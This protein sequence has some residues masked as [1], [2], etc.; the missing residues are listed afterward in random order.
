MPTPRHRRHCHRRR[1]RRRCRQ[2]LRPGRRLRH[3]RG[4][5]RRRWRRPPEGRAGRSACGSSPRRP[6]RRAAPGGGPAAC[7]HRCRT[8][9][10]GTARSP[11][12][13]AAVAGRAVPARPKAPPTSAASWAAPGKRTQLGVGA[14]VGAG[15]GVGVEVRVGVRVGV[16]VLG[17]RGPEA[18]LGF[19]L[20]PPGVARLLLTLVHHELA[21]RDAAGR[22]ARLDPLVQPRQQLARA[23]A[24]QQ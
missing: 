17:L 12:P 24:E 23:A 14:G 2:P 11:V 4:W 13:A 8:Y 20:A 10:T 3:A 22:V 21:E 6:R 19:G 9:R 1:R 15:V 5:R 16:R 18:G 7:S